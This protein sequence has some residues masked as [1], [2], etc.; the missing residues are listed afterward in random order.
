MPAW[1]C[2]ILATCE[3]MWKCI[4][5]SDS[6]MFSARRRSITRNTSAAAQRG[7]AHAHAEQRGDPERARLLDH[8][9]ELG[10]LLDH[11]VHPQPEALADERQADELAV[12]VAIA[13][14]DAIGTR[15]R[16]HGQQLGLGA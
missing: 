8:E 13:H 4:M 2:C 16:Q 10:E 1:M 9:P 3:P 5:A 12:L 14:D 7:Q 15:T 6:S 11:D